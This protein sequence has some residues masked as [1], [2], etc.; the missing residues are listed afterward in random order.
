MPAETVRHTAVPLCPKTSS[1]LIKWRLQAQRQ[2]NAKWKRF[3]V[4]LLKSVQSRFF[5]RH[6]LRSGSCCVYSF[7]AQQIWWSG[8]NDKESHCQLCDVIHLGGGWNAVSRVF[9]VA[10]NV[11]SWQWGCLWSSCV[12]RMESDF[13]LVHECSKQIPAPKLFQI[14]QVWNMAS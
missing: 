7:I 13:P 12:R 14:R 1:E 9:D 2:G 10:W 5:C 8:N 3:C 6:L 11:R 4:S